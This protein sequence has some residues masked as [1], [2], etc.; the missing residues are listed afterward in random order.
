MLLLFFFLFI[1]TS[2]NSQ[3]SKDYDEK[4][5]EEMKQKL[6]IYGS[7]FNSPFL[8]PEIFHIYETDTA[9]FSKMLKREMN[10]TYIYNINDCFGYVGY[11]CQQFFFKKMEEY[12][13]TLSEKRR[14]SLDSMK[15]RFVVF[16]K[17]EPPKKLLTLFKRECYNSSPDNNTNIF[18]FYFIFGSEENFMPFFDDEGLRESYHWVFD[19][20]FEP[21]FEIRPSTKYS[22]VYGQRRAKY[23]IN[24]WKDTKHPK[25]RK[26]VDHLKIYVEK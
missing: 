15:R 20:M 5:V 13:K 16:E 3:T 21:L 14:E 22:T 6:I 2:C 17:V 24:R 7:Y 11:T 10:D 25:I 19:N 9:F 12:K 23:I 26:Y 1:G 8:I 4:T 18:L